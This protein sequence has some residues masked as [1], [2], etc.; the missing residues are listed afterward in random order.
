MTKN[1]RA[2]LAAALASALDDFSDPALRGAVLHAKAKMADMIAQ[3]HGFE[4][5]SDFNAK[6]KIEMGRAK[7]GV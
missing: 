6:W 5:W 2:Q 7:K 3:K 1:D 4:Q